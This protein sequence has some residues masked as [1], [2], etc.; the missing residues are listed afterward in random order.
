M[1]GQFG[2]RIENVVYTKKIEDKEFVEI[3]DLTMIPIQK[4]MIDFSQLEPYQVF[5]C[6][7][8]TIFILETNLMYNSIDFSRF[9]GLKKFQSFF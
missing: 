1:D 9:F 5:F 8:H 7:V 3:V 2:V 6:Y 4:K